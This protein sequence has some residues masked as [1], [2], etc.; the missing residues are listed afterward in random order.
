MVEVLERLAECS[1]ISAPPLQTRGLGHQNVHHIMD[2]YS[3]DLVVVVDPLAYLDRAL[4]LWVFEKG[5]QVFL[6]TTLRQIFPMFRS[7]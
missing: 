6:L 3:N 1:I 2:N 4:F 7:E 5:Q